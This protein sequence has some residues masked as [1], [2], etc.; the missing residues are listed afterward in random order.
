MLGELAVHVVG[1]DTDAAEEAAQHA[2]LLLQQLH[3][4]RHPVVLAGQDLDPLLGVA[5]SNLCLL[6]RLADGHV[7][8]LAAAPVLVRRLVPLLLG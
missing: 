7:V 1:Q 5:G 4:L 2:K 8:A 3:L 6:S